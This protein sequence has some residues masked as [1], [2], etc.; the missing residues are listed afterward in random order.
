L[1]KKIKNLE[2]S[3]KEKDSLLKTAKDSLAEACLRG[4]KQNIQ[5]SEKNKRTKELNRELKKTK[6][7]LQNS[8]SHFNHE[9]EDLKLKV[10]DEADKNFKLSESLK[11]LRDRCFGFVTQCSSRLQSIFNSVGAAS[12]EAMHSANDILNALDWIK[13][14][15]DDLDEAIVGH[16]DF[17]AFVVAYGTT[18]IFAKAGC[19]HLKT[20][21]KA[22]F[23]IFPS[24]LDNI[25]VEGRSVGKRFIIQIWT[26]GGREVVE[27]EAWALIDEV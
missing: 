11:R 17:F 5:I 7:T 13:K 25:P 4:E 24:D 3:L 21:N 19:K 9:I 10:K 12:E 6:S 14:E 8:V 18:A 16:G 15:I 20:I 27:N 26:K 22:T 2:N 23:G 1:E